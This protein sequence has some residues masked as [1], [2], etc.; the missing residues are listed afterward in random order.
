[1]CIKTIK[2]WLASALFVLFASGSP[3]FV[4]G[5]GNIAIAQT[6]YITGTVVDDFG[7]PIIG[8][9]IRVKDTTKGAITDLNGKFSLD[10]APGQIIEISFVGFSTQTVA[11]VSGM[12]IILKEDTQSL[13]DVVVVGY[14]V[15]KKKLVTGA[16]VQ[17]KGD[18]IQKLSTTSALTAMQSQSPGVTIMQNNGQA[19]EGFKVNIRGLGT[20]GNSDPLYVVDG[21]AGGSLNDLNPADIESIDVLKDAASAA[22][23]GARA[24][25]G[26]IL[27][28]TKQGKSGKL[29][30][31]Y[32]GY[33]GQQY[34]YK[35]PDVLNAQEY[36]Y[37]RQL[38]EF[39]GG[40]AEP[41]W[42]AKLPAAIYESLFDA[43]GNVLRNGGRER[44]GLT[45]PT[46]KV[47]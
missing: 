23:Y 26:V 17:V 15:Q 16:T 41:E 13:D 46:T 7:E 22:I 40:A 5:G 14:G 45:S 11:A 20:T 18:D 39:N 47:P 30:I 6:Q 42:Q 35:A 4:N 43:D 27:I 37:S 2:S 21:V 33:Y 44:T 32:D 25:N 1:M 29:Q 31:S 38:R 19:G 24:A 10:V 36:I 8:A 28:T 34:L 9:N 12:K 3:G